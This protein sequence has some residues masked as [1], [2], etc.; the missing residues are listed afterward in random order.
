MMWCMVSYCC[1][2]FEPGRDLFGLWKNRYPTYQQA[3]WK[4]V[5]GQLQVGLNKINTSHCTPPRYYQSSK[6][7]QHELDLSWRVAQFY[8]ILSETEPC[9]L[10]LSG[11][12]VLPQQAAVPHHNQSWHSFYPSKTNHN[13][14]QY[15]V[16]LCEPCCCLVSMYR[17][18]F[19]SLRTVERL[20]EKQYIVYSSCPPLYNAGYDP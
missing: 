11:Y 4:C 5:K 10:R 9:D 12:R 18:N 20:P 3:L 7:T 13:I 14:L 19:T 1:L 6:R 15:G 2:C 8:H 16:F 17:T